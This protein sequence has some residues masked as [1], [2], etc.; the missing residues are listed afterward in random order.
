[1]NNI[2]G[3]VFDELYLMKFIQCNVLHAM[4]T[5]YCILSNVL[6]C[7]LCIYLTNSIPCIYSLNCIQ[8]NLFHAFDWLFHISFSMHSIPPNVICIQF[9]TFN[10]S[11]FIHCIPCM[12]FVALWILRPWN[13]SNAVQSVN[14][15]SKQTFLNGYHLFPLCSPPFP[16]SPGTSLPCSWQLLLW[17]MENNV[18]YPAQTLLA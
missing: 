13:L 5:M 10:S 6:H 4:Y 8:C 18:T 15:H 1:M 7:I 14:R 2:L 17:S 9:N 11:Y 3:F 16:L 12:L